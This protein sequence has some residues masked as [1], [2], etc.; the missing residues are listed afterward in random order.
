MCPV[1]DPFT[2]TKEV[3]LMSTTTPITDNKTNGDGVVLMPPTAGERVLAKLLG[4][5]EE[6]VQD[7]EKDVVFLKGTNFE[8]EQRNRSLQGGFDHQMS[9]RQ[10]Y[11]DLCHDER[12]RNRQLVIELQGR[13]RMPSWMSD[14]GRFIAD[15]QDSWV[16]VRRGLSGLRKE[17]RHAFLRLQGRGV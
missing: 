12:H 15:V 13:L 5:A 3:T 2:A 8:L 17:L 1:T 6:R 14:L 11:E 4:E 16:F 7:L 10:R 9:A